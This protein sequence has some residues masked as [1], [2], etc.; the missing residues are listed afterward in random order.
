MLPTPSKLISL[1]SFLSRAAPTRQGDPTPRVAEKEAE[2]YR[3]ATILLMQAIALHAVDGN[4]ADYEQFRVEMDRLGNGLTPNAG[5]AEFRAAAGGAAKALEEYNRQTIKFGRQQHAELQ[6]IIS[7]LT[8]TLIHIGT[9]SESSAQS[10]QNIEKALESARL[11]EDIH[12]LRGR[13]SECLDAVRNE[14]LRR[15]AEDRKTIEEL[16]KELEDSQKRML[17][18]VQPKDTDPATGLPGKREAEK[19]IE[20]AAANPANNKVAILVV[21]RVQAVNAR[22]GYSVGDQML[23]VASEHFRKNLSVRDQLYRWQGPALVALLERAE[24]IDQVRAEVQHIAEEKLERTVEIGARTVLIPISANW[25][26][27]Q[28]TGSAQS[29]VK[30]IEAFTAAQAPKDYV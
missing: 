7:M 9:S 8:R 6:N 11:M 2:D 22:F 18:G 16:Q 4:A 13:L 17:E 23:Q 28:V 12:G 5:A 30:Q 15:R 14:S 26:V 27:F 19:A 1:K 29:L 25:A 20:Q 10:L 24:R 3:S 21:N